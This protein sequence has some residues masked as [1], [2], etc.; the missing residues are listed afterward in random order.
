V[1]LSGYCL[2]ARVAIRI[3]AAFPDR[4]AAIA[5]FHGGNLGTDKEDSPHLVADKLKA[6][7]YM[8]YADHDDGALPEQRARLD[9]ALAEAGIP[10]FSEVYTDAPHGYTMRDTEA[11][12]KEAAEKHFANLIDLLDRRLK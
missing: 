2:G 6:E 8:G 1:G 11:Y 4:I 3:G 5:G 7:V 12:R 9:K 10:H